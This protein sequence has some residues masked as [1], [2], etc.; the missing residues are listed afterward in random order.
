MPETAST[1]KGLPLPPVVHAKLESAVLRNGR[2]LIVGDVH[3]CPAELEDLLAK[4]NFKAD[5][6]KLILVG[7]LVGKG[8]QSAQVVQMAR[9]LNAAAVRGNWDEDALKARELEG[10]GQPVPPQHASFVGTLEPEDWAYLQQLPFSLTLQRHGLVVTHAGLVPGIPLQEQALHNLVDMRHVEQIDATDKSKGWKTVPKFPRDAG[11]PWGQ[12]YEGES[13]HVVYGHHARRRLQK[14]EY[15]TGID[16]G[17][18]LGDNL[19][20]LVLPSVSEL[21]ARGF[22]PHKGVTREALGAEL[23]SVK[24]RQAYSK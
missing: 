12:A 20:A 1:P 11:I 24:A 4:C 21:E 22:N 16:T 9:C 15:C 3:G 14:W 17:C 7:D 10:A 2:A 5:Q 23:V 8:Q 13:G 19:T 18:V 6:D